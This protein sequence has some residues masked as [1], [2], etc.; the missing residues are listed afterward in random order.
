L[1]HA[2]SD[3]AAASALLARRTPWLWDVRAFW[4]DQRIALGVMR[5]G[6]PE[7]RVMRL[8]ERRAAAACAAM[9]VLAASAIDVLADRHGP[10]VAAKCHVIPTCVDLD[11]FGV[12]PLPPP[13]TVRLVLAGTLNLY[14]DVPA[15]LRFADHLG[16]LLPTE[17][18][19]LA[20][21][22]TAWDAT[23]PSAGARLARATPE[24][25]PNLLAASH[26]GLC[27]CRADAGVSLRAAMPTKLGELLACGRPVVVNSG[28]GD[29]DSLLSGGECGVVLRDTSD[30]ELARAA[31]HV[32]RLLADPS[33]P[34][35]CRALAQ[36]HFDLDDGV[37]RLLGIYAELGV[38]PAIT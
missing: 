27:V 4:A 2:R 32:T 16:R 7:E 19:V 11:R 15:M 13:T 21:E 24:D 31:D 37:D 5:A 36:R 20:P 29:M 6:S 1:I 38:E 34:E 18:V 3:L 35:R 26:V 8:V 22:A 28:L 33:T 17:V 25:M 14:Y 10:E 23:L 12:T 9:V 30:A